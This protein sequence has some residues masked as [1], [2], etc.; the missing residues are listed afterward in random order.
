[1]SQQSGV[2]SVVE[3]PVGRTQSRDTSAHLNPKQHTSRRLLRSDA[4]LH[5]LGSVRCMLKAL[6]RMRGEEMKSYYELAWRSLSSIGSS[7]TDAA[8]ATLVS[9]SAQIR[10]QVKVLGK[11]HTLNA[12]SRV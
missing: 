11:R 10:G 3:R 7:K 5:H 9:N 1:M 6:V 12:H 8:A 4:S 2:E